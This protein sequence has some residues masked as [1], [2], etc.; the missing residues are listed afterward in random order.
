MRKTKKLSINIRNKILDFHKRGK[1]YRSI[2]KQFNE[3][4]S[5]VGSIII[6]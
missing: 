3:H 2:E 1:G 4:P 5:T 6:K